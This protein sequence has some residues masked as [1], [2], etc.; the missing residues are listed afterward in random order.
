MRDDGHLPKKKISKSL[1]NEPQRTSMK[2][3]ENLYPRLH[4]PA[5]APKTLSATTG[6]TL[7]RGWRRALLR[8]GI[9]HINVRHLPH[10][11]TPFAT[12]AYGICHTSVRHLPHLQRRGFQLQK[13]L[14]RKAKKSDVRNGL[15]QAGSK[16]RTGDKG[17][18]RA[19][20]TTKKHQKRKDDRLL[21]DFHA[22]AAM[23]TDRQ[24]DRDS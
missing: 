11:R 5:P 8:Y 9:C 1:S 15:N 13:K 10:Q 17:R 12:S 22:I 20:N 2:T 6:G 16:Q 24:K 21:A 3:T 23:H 19:G 14:S 4:D 7:H 18:K